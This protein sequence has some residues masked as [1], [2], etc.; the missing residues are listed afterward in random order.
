MP[1]KDLY[2]AFIHSHLNNLKHKIL[3]IYVR[4]TERVESFCCWWWW[5]DTHVYAIAIAVVCNEPG[6][7]ASVHDG[8][9]IL[10]WCFDEIDLFI[11]LPWYIAANHKLIV[12]LQPN[13]FSL[14]LC[15]IQVCELHTSTQNSQYILLRT[16]YVYLSLVQCCDDAIFC[17]NYCTNKLL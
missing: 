3:C 1:G 13:V 8:K 9:W 15:F 10:K 17:F 16:V 5:W 12:S 2:F 4:G 6:M 14:L 11:C 7:N